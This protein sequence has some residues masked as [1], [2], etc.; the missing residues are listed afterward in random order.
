MDFGLPRV[1]VDNS[2]AVEGFG[3]ERLKQYLI[4]KSKKNCSITLMFFMLH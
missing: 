1:L 2:S 3:E 4:Q